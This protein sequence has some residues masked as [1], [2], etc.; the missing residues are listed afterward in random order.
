MRRLIDYARRKPGQAF[1][2]AI[3]ALFLI[4]FIGIPLATVRV[5]IDLPPAAAQ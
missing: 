4:I 1:A 3:A 5:R 2:L